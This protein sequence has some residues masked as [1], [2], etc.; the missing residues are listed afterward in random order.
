MVL[1]LAQIVTLLFVCAV[2]S[3]ATL[4]EFKN[5]DVIFQTSKSSQSLAIQRA[6][7]S[8]Y[9]HMGIIFLRGGRPFVFEASSTVRYTPLQDWIARGKDGKYVVKRLRTELS[10]SQI[11]RLR[12]VAATLLGRPYDLTFEWSDSRI[13]CSELVWKI[14]DRALNVHIGELQA[15]REFDLSDPAVRAKMKERYGGSVPLNEKVISPAAMFSAPL[16][17]PVVAA[18]T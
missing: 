5:G 18:G 9:S 15:L 17:V 10:D 16:L 13:Y 1:R 11:K 3:A 6:T 2:A 12:E 4:P 14:Y 7:H 8:K